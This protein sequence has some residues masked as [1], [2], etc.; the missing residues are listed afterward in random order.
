MA[1]PLGIVLLM[2]HLISY[3]FNIIE[4]RL[5]WGCSVIGCPSYIALMEH[6]LGE[7]GVPVRAEAPFLPDSF[8]R[9]L[10][11]YDPGMINRVK[12]EIPPQLLQKRI[13]VLSGNDDKLVP[14]NASKKFINAFQKRLE[15]VEKGQIQLKNNQTPGKLEVHTYDGVGHEFTDDMKREFDKW[16]LQF[17]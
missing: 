11:R 6:R 15:E 12:Q 16:I 9:V 8:K 14:W 3:C 1:T 5:K 7:S 10:G 2:V 17:I 13:L 4:E